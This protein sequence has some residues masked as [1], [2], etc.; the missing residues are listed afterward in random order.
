MT[1]AVVGG[2]LSGLFTAIGLIELGLDDV[3]V[4][5]ESEEQGG[6]TK[7]IQRDGFSLEP[8]VGTMTLPHPQMS[9][10]LARIEADMSQ[11]DPVASVR[12]V[13]TG[14]R[15]VEIPATPKALMAPI[16]PPGAKI[17]ALAELLLRSSPESDD[18]SL[19]QF[20]RR[21]FGKR[22][23][24]MLAWLMASGVYA[25]DPVRLSARSAFPVLTGLEDRHRSVLR[26]ALRRRG[27]RAPEGA[28]P[29]PHVPVG[30]MRALT[31]AAAKYLGDRFRGGFEVSSVRQTGGG[32]VVD[33][34]ETLTVD[35]VVVTTR[36]EIAARV[37]GDDLARHL[38]TA[39]AAPVVVVGIGGHANPSPLPPGFG[40]LI[41]P[42]SGLVSLGMLFESSYAPGRAPEGSW[43]MKV[44]GGGATRPDVVDWD[45]ER[46]IEV[47]GDEA[48]RLLGANLD[49]GFAEVIRHSPGIP[50]YDVGHGQWLASLQELLSANPGLHLTGWGYRGVGA[51]QLATDAAKVAEAVAISYG[52]AG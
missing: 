47:V 35:R 38:T 42:G 37:I 26:G 41:G 50:Q 13:Y 48:S 12:Y 33:G 39:G 18:E 36:P 14:D 8:A 30:G 6:A 17:R 19:Q 28:R 16:L 11:V 3:L 25:G 44:I 32:W 7:T 43:L 22:A 34:P 15:M 23:G 1:V 2:G 29:L 20:C 40:V 5:E 10:I 45:D 9:P 27:D 52:E 31:G 21:R 49:V 24:D 51:S 4:L 46:L